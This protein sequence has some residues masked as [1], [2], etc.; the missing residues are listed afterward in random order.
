M[1]FKRKNDD[2]QNDFKGC[3]QAVYT[4]SGQ[5]IPARRDGYPFQK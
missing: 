1:S 2:Q 3:F 4:G 5:D